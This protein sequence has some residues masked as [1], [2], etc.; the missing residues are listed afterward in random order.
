MGESK[1]HTKICLSWLEGSE[2]TQTRKKTK[3][4]K[5]INWIN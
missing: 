5:H 2:S 4:G 3:T 1:T